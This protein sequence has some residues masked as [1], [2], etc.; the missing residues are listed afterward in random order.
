MADGARHSLGFIA[1]SNWGVTPATPA[2]Q[3]VRNAS[4]TLAVNKDTLLSEEIR[5]DR[6][7]WDMRQGAYKVT[8][9]VAGEMSYGTYDSWLEALTGGT[10]A[11]NELKAGTTRRSFTLE[12][13]FNDI[14][15]YP[16][17]RFTGVELDK[18]SLTVAA[19]QIA[20]CTWSFMGK[21]GNIA[22]AAIAGSSNVDPSTT[23]VF[24]GF[25][26][27]INEGGSP[28]SVIT[29]MQITI[30]NGLNPRFVV[31]SKYT[32][33]P[34]IGYFNIAG[35]ATMWFADN[36]QLLKFIN[37]NES[38]LD[39]TLT[40]L[41]G[42]DL[43]FNIPRIKYTGAPPNVNGIGPITLAMPFQALLDSVTHDSNIVITRTAA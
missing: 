35:T 1:E 6:Q 17:H 20:K 9:D 40:D 4:V 12:R 37:E 27:T 32:L 24:D 30:E 19:N 3:L 38:S 43:E 7:R 16:Y 18:L 31:G 2:F 29:E 15:D 28:V 21:D 22:A 41:D 39:F 14:V 13:T 11:A 25:T 42:N 34:S 23:H 33:R 10:W 36:T 5:S 8:G 26:G